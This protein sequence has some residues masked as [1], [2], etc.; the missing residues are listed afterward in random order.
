M[1]RRNFV[2]ALFG[3]STAAAATVIATSEAQAFTGPALPAAA[4]SAEDALWRST[5][6]AQPEVQKTFLLGRSLFRMKHLAARRRRQRRYGR[7]RH[8]H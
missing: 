2:M 6:L 3:V 8:Y 1:N 4:P 7:R 5:D